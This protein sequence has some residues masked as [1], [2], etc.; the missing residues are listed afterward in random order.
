MKKSERADLELISES[1]VYRSCIPLSALRGNEGEYYI[2]VA[3]DK[4]TIL[5]ME[6]V[7]VRIPVTVEEKN[8]SYAAVIGSFGM[9]A[10]VIEGAGKVLDS[11]DRVRISEGV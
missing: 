6:T 11:G 8:D 1:N 5:G 2:L 3:E 9:D 7:A 10:K 4:A